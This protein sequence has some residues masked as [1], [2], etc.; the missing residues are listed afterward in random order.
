M[1]ITLKYYKICDVLEPL[2]FYVPMS[3][4]DRKQTGYQ[5]H[6][7]ISNYLYEVFVDFKDFKEIIMGIFHSEKFLC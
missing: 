1:W 3:S 2:C 5:Y 4:S 6:G 7:L